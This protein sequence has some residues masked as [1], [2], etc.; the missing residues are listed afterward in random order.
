MTASRW[1]S[2]GPVA[3]LLLSL[4]V[5]GCT[6]PVPTVGPGP[7][8]S[9]IVTAGPTCPV[10]QSEPSDCA[11]RPISGAVLILS[12][13]DGTEIARATSGV[14]GSYIFGI[15]LSEGPVIV[16]GLPVAGLTPPAPVTVDVVAGPGA[17]QVNL[18]DDT[19][20]R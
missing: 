1:S 11:P 15:A 5:F 2:A 18:E 9:G 6:S 12:D 10:V 13:P 4:V 3:V 20:S 8:I 7:T 16:S 17:M 19:G 14:D